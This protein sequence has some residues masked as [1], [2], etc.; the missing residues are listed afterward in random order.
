MY[1]F[2]VSHCQRLLVGF[3]SPDQLKGYQDYTKAGRRRCEG[4][5][6]PLGQPTHGLCHCS[7]CHNNAAVA[8]IAASW[9]ALSPW[10]IPWHTAFSFLTV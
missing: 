4:R 2:L 9:V 8:H 6:L 3:A 10:A 7:Y 1:D 5:P